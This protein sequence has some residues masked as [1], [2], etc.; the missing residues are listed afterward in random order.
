MSVNAIAPLINRYLNPKDR[1]AHPKAL[2]TGNDLMRSLNIPPGQQIGKVLLEIQLAQV[3][4]KISTREEAL[5]L[6]AKLIQL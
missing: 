3:E 1:V 5:A 6:A 2:I 4:G